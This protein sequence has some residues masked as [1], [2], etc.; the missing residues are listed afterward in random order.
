MLD[1]KASGVIINGHL[2]SVSF[3]VFG[4]ERSEEET[5]AVMVNIKNLFFFCLSPSQSCFLTSCTGAGFSTT[6]QSCLPWASLRYSAM[7]GVGKV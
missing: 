3:A 2:P 7:G 5:S 1:M 6:R 4:N